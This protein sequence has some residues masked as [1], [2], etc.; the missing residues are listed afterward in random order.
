[1]MDRIGA[2]Q[3]PEHNAQ[4]IAPMPVKP[5]K[6]RPP[7]PPRVKKPPKPAHARVTDLLL[8]VLAAASLGLSGW[9]LATLLQAAG[10]PIWVAGLGVGVFDL[11]ALAAGLQVYARRDAP[12]TA[13]GARLV[14]MVSLIASSVVNG[15]HG[16]ALGG[17]TTAA[18]L[19]AAPLSFE[20]V[21]ELRHRTLTALVWVLFRKETALALRRDAWTRIA[22]IVANPP[23]VEIERTDSLNSGH[24]HPAHQGRQVES[25]TASTEIGR[26]VGSIELAAAIAGQEW[27]ELTKAD[28]RERAVTDVL[29]AKA[30]ASTEGY[31][32]DWH[33]ASRK[34]DDSLAECVEV[35]VPVEEVL[36]EVAERGLTS[37]DMSRTSAS[38]ITPVRPDARAETPQSPVSAKVSGTDED[39]SVRPDAPKAPEPA[40]QHESPER[41]ER[42]PE[43]RPPSVRSGVH[44]L[45]GMGQT[46][47]AA[48]ARQLGQVLGTEPPIETVA[49]YV[50][51]ARN[52]KNGSD[53]VTEPEDHKKSGP[54]L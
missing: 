14:M 40:P 9:S 41:P 8:A 42:V 39:K 13:G 15:A 18:V 29:R 20:V 16:A 1:M 36:R 7:K 49:R 52:S 31:G 27:P 50:R 34:S 53:P 46:D 45:V 48:I 21:F 30:W 22:P 54:Y 35:G 5:K 47:A 33:R 19:A 37:G 24:N 12:H 38:R 25:D 23:T 17:W 6:V 11:V 51:E 2:D 44:L 43:Q 10:A 26:A 28:V 32:P 4:T 3:A